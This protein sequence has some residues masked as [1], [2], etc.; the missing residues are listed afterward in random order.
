MLLHGLST[1]MLH[2]IPVSFHYQVLGFRL[3]Q[4]TALKAWVLATAR[5][6]NKSVGQLTYIFVSDE[7]LLEM[8]RQHLQHNYFTDIIT[9]DLSEGGGMVGE[10]YISVDRVRENAKTLGVSFI[11]EMRRVMVHGLLHLCGF[12]DKTGAETIAM[13]EA[14]D[15]AL[16]ACSSK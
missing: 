4:A 5:Q 13:R 14:E 16:S 1:P 8:N 10:L 3:R 15:M 7:A 2:F 9:F 6:H 12:R 11:Q